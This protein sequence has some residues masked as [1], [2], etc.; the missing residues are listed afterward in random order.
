MA[1]DGRRN[2]ANT[3]AFVIYPE[4]LPDGWLEILRDTHVPI[5]LSPLHDRDVWTEADE[6]ANPEHKA[7]EPKKPHRHGVMYFESLKTPDQALEVLEPL[8][9][10]RVE[11]VYAPKAYNRYLC[12]LDDPEKAQYPI[13]EVVRLN[14]ADCSMVRELTA[15]E[16]EAMQRD[17]QR[18]VID[19]GI[20]EYAE[21]MDYCLESNPDWLKIVR[22]QTITWRGYL[23][24]RRGMV[25]YEQ[26]RRHE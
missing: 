25:A 12:H 14:G 5:A 3:W 23:A 7:G 22:S 13:E 18:F 10:K 2:R 9:V 6:E 4:S 15:D 8:G 19:T 20:T 17:I 16:R 1:K 11:R 24:S 21:L 26:G